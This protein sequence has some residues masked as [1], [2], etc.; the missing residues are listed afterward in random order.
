MA[1]NYYLNAFRFHYA[2]FEGRAR[3]SEYWYFTL[4]NIIISYGLMGMMFLGEGMYFMYF[5]SVLYSLGSL[6]P[7]LAV[8]VRRLHDI[9]KSGWYFL[10][11]LI[12]VAGIIW[13]LVL[14]VTNSQDGENEY[15]PNPK[16]IGNNNNDDSMIQN[17]G[18]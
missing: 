17:I 8:A 15:G 18:Q 14:L 13:L 6:I 3:R 11:F 5:V 10:V 12:P 2:D 16:G 7:S 1:F 9:G 4:F